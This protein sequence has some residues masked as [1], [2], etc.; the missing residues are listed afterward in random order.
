MINI[1]LDWNGII[2]LKPEFERVYSPAMRSIREWYKQGKIML[3][4]PSPIRM[5]YYNSREKRHYDENQWNEELRNVG[6]EDVKLR[7]PTS[8]FFKFP[9]LQWILIREIHDRI[10]PDIA[11]SDREIENAQ[12]KLAMGRQWNSQK[13]DALSVYTFA[14]WSDR[15]DVFVSYDLK[16]I[17]ANRDKLYKPYEVMVAR[18]TEALIHGEQMV[19]L[20]EKPEEILGH[21]IIPGHIMTP[22]ETVNY[23]QEQL[24][25]SRQ[26]E[27][28]NHSERYQAQGDSN[29][30]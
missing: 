19:I 3:W 17:I 25:E 2:G 8:R 10:F 9:G 24:E 15:D 16:H 1:Y 21:V 14:T 30:A 28:T 13:N 7:S 29:Y 20:K 4:I 23:L 12:K 5:E 6:L 18:P 11:F 22:Q 26:V 27:K